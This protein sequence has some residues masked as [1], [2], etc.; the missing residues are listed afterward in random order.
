MVSQ[1]YIRAL[2]VIGHHT[3]FAVSDDVT[4]LFQRLTEA[5]NTMTDFSTTSAWRAK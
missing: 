5:T 1:P 3:R 2:Q 4:G